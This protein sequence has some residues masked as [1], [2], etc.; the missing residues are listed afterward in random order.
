MRLLTNPGSNVPDSALARYD[1]L[2]ARQTIV[3]DHVGHDTRHATPLSTVDH[4]VATAKEFPKVAGST[5]QDMVPLFLDALEH[6]T[7]LLVVMTSKRL[8]S[9]YHSAQAAA[10]TVKSRLAHKS[11]DIRIVD[12]QSTDVGAG[13]ITIAAGEAIRA[14]LPMNDIVALLETMAER[15][16]L[17]MHVQNLLHPIKSGRA[18]F[19]RAWMASVLQ[20]R[21]VMGITDG[22]LRILGRV[23]EK[24]DPVQ[25]LLAHHEERMPKRPRV[26]MGIVHGNEP[27]RAERCAAAFRERFDV[28]FELIRPLSSSIY[29]YSGPGSLGVFLIPMDAL[30]W[31][32]PV[33]TPALL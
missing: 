16:A 1:I 29:L 15:G 32:V 12:T 31:D 2:L 20:V 6:D 22:D 24:D 18:G 7:E 9:S 33:P 25:V 4:W 10:A 14:G 8:I 30:P 23:R 21:P 11:A 19:L 13:L 26:W 17:A 5:A 3:V 28:A 27:E